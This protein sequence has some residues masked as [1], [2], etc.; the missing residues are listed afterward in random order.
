M[1]FL[2]QKSKTFYTLKSSQILK[3]LEIENYL[4][5]KDFMILFGL[6]F[7]ASKSLKTLYHKRGYVRCLVNHV[8]DNFLNL[9]NSS[10]GQ[11]AS[12]Q[13]ASEVEWA[14]ARC[15]ISFENACI[16]CATKS[17]AVIDRSP[18][19]RYVAVALSNGMLR[20]YQYPTTTIMVIFSF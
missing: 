18:D 11:S 10:T 16:L 2:I 17:V 14:S 5:L 1:N 20:F 6:H 13:E 15:Q 19:K 7:Y 4:S 8:M 9:G 12:V 3:L